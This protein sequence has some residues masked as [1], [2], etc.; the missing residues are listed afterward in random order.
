MVDT[1]P[2]MGTEAMEVTSLEAM[3]TADINPEAMAEVMDLAT[4]TVATGTVVTGTAATDMGGMEGMEVM[5]V[6]T[7]KRKFITSLK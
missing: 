4:D 2:V 6:I 7:D 5:E 1:D 3:D